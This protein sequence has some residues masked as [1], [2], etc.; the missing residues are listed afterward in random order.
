[1]MKTTMKIAS[2]MVEIVVDFNWGKNVKCAHVWILILKVFFASMNPQVLSIQV[3]FLA[4][5]I[6]CNN[7]AT[8]EIVKNYETTAQ[9]KV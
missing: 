5:L 6:Q 3:L 8:V 9:F 2:S 4:T 1:M 7:I